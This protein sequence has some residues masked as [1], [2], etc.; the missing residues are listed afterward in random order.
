ML[1]VNPEEYGHGLPKAA[2]ES[3]CREVMAGLYVGRQS[4][5]VVAA[6]ERP[7]RATEWV[8]VPWTGLVVRHIVLAVYP[9]R[10]RPAL[11]A[12]RRSADRA[13]VRG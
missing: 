8:F 12:V 4:D 3:N 13:A 5:V 10:I 2:Q 7:R 11:L 1:V 6:L 9:L